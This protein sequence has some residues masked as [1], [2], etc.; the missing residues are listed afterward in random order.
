MAHLKIYLVLN[1]ELMNKPSCVF[2]LWEHNNI[3]PVPDNFFL[4]IKETNILLNVDRNKC[5]V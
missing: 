1:S 4:Y 5:S 2:P 3:R